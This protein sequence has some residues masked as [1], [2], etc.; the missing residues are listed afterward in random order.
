M[1]QFH[2]KNFGPIEEGAVDFGDLTVLVGPQAS[3]KSLFLQGFKLA[4]DARCIRSDI[5]AQGFQWRNAEEFFN[6]Y[7]GEG[8]GGLVQSNETTYN[9][10]TGWKS[11]TKLENGGSR[12]TD[13][14]V[15][16]IPAQR[17]MSIMDGWPRNFL[18]FSTQDPY[19]VKS[20]SEKLRLLMEADFS[21]F[22]TSGVFP[23]SNR[24]KN[25]IREKLNA[26]IFHNGKVVLDTQ[27]SRKRVMLEVN[28]AQLPYMVWSAGQREF[29]PLLL[30]LYFL[31]PPAKKSKQDHIEYVVIE[32]PEMGLHPRAI[33]ALLVIVV[34]LLSR[35]Y[36]VL[37][38]THSTLILDFV[39]AHNQVPSGKDT[40]GAASKFRSL[41]EMPG[42]I[43]TKRMF[44]ELMSKSIKA[45]YFGRESN[46]KVKVKDVS[47]LDLGSD[48]LAL[49][50]WGGLTSFSAKVNELVAGLNS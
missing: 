27:T 43:A 29:M 48:D 40:K 1:A 5:Q 46:D 14:R 10:G 45:Y 4:T 36:K 18:N 34:D 12:S 2:L 39:W 25:A 30:G 8:M 35:G 7:F 19:V 26:S 16:L 23:K 13:Q 33:E 47:S 42:D 32:E 17:V 11:F 28:G 50:E 3:G 37:I 9:T 15:F 49:S 38:S 21:S 44:E 24:L 22:S 31:M 41:F 6:L 20:F